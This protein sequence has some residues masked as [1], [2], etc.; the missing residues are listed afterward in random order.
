M[1]QN[2]VASY[3]HVQD[4]LFVTKQYRINVFIIRETR[5]PL[6]KRNTRES[7]HQ[8]TKF[9]LKRGTNYQQ[10]IDSKRNRD[11][12]PSCPAKYESCFF[13]VKN[14]NKKMKNKVALS[15]GLPFVK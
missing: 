11:P 1:F 10:K 9:N 3:Y 4:T 5:N 13:Q 7:Y 6:L 15:A 14:K 2:T 12:A 8:T